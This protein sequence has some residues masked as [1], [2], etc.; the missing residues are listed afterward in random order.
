MGS[1]ICVNGKSMLCVICV[2]AYGSKV[3]VNASCYALVVVCI[4]DVLIMCCCLRLLCMFASVCFIH[5]LR[6]YAFPLRSC[7]TLGSVLNVPIE[8]L[9]N[10]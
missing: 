4:V 3:V 2:L 9:T 5:D 6:M 1:A 7:N 8:H 10:C